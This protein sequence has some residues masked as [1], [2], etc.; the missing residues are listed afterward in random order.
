[1]RLL[2][3]IGTPRP[4]GSMRVIMIERRPVIVHSSSKM[5]AWREYVAEEAPVDWASS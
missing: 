2:T 3:I 1:M 4:Q 5:K